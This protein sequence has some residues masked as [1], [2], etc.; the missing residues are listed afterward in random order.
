MRNLL[1]LCLLASACSDE[2]LV[3]ENK[4]GVPCAVRL[5]EIL[6]NEEA[7]AVTCRPSVSVCDENGV[8]SC[9]D[10][11]PPATEEICGFLE[12]DDC[13]ASTTEA[14][15]RIHPGDSRNRCRYTEQGACKSASVICIDGE[16]VCDPNF[17]RP[18]VC[19][20]Q[21]EDEDCDGLVNGMDPS[22][23]L[24]VPPFV[25]DG[26]IS[27]VNVGICRAG[28][29][30]C[31]DGH[32]VY[33][34]MIT[35]QEEQC[36]NRLDDDCDGFV[37]EASDDSDPRSFLLVVDYSGSM[38]VYI[39][40]V[41][42]ALCNWSLSRPQDVFGVA[43]FGVSGRRE[44][45]LMISPFSSAADAC[46]DMLSLNYYPGG[47]E[48][49]ANATL[50]FLD[51]EDWLTEE[52]AVIIFTD[53]RYQ[54]YLPD[55]ADRLIEGCDLNDYTVGVYT[56]RH[57]HDSFANIAAGCNGWLDDLSFYP[58]QMIN[59]LTSRFAGICE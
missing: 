23:T 36:G 14:D 57:L 51:G 17:S 28:V 56:L 59:S 4:C 32:Q 43:A 19:D 20:T 35:P 53:E 1:L 5:R 24:T 55:D 46:A 25:Y 42:I 58:E 11:M 3:P 30:R 48:Y 38:D 37:D 6:F 47:I 26:D 22:M 7:L 54:E 52:R 10:Y 40:S 12:D 33:D 9:P 31:I 18:E 50:R 41:E 27:T 44:E 49:A 45:Y 21:F 8:P 29:A 16:L 2:I 15:I 34:G 13:D 39:D